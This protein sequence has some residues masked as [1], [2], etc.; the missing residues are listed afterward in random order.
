MGSLPGFK[1]SKK[2]L[3]SARL[4]AGVFSPSSPVALFFAIFCRRLARV[5][6]ETVGQAT[7][8]V[9]ALDQKLGT[10]IVARQ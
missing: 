6:S 3:P 5:P 10:P 8:K 2:S 7:N 1:F 4:L 9:F